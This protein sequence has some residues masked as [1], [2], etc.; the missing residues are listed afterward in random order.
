MK[1]VTQPSGRAATPAM[2]QKKRK[3]QPLCEETI[4]LDKIQQAVVLVL[5]GSSEPSQAQAGT[6]DGGEMLA[7]Q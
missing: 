7:G 6:A 2:L 5:C 1:S 4:Q 3:P